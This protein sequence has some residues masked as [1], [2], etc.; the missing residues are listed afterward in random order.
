MK[1]DTEKMFSG[2]GGVVKVNVHSLGVD[3]DVS[4]LSSS[5]PGKYAQL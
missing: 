3:G 1:V 2:G 4:V 5:I